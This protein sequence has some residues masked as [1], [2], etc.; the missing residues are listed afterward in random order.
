VREEKRGG[1]RVAF[2]P[3]TEP[4][5]GRYRESLTVPEKG[6]STPSITTTKPTHTPLAKHFLKV[7]WRGNGSSS[8]PGKPQR[9][10][11]ERTLSF[12]PLVPSTR[13]T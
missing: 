8:L 3:G 5:Q 12:T 11:R 13:G 6:I 4:P 7:P 9:K 10:R 2:T 1:S